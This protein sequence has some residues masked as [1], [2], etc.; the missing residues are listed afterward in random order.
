MSPLGI[1]L[2]TVKLVAHCLKTKGLDKLRGSKEFEI[3]DSQFVKVIMLT[4][5]RTGRFYVRD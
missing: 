1:E 5:L 3:H 4:I 2:T